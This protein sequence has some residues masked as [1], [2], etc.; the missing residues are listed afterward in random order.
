MS[1]PNQ[2]WSAL[3]LRVLNGN[4]P[5]VL[6]V[7]RA[8]LLLAFA[9]FAAL[10]VFR[11]PPA[12]AIEPNMGPEVC[13]WGDFARPEDTAWPITNVLGIPKAVIRAM[14]DPGQVPM[15]PWSL[16]GAT[17]TFDG[18]KIP[19]PMEIEFPAFYD[20]V[21]GKQRPMRRVHVEIW[22]EQA[23]AQA[24]MGAG[25]LDDEGKFTLEATDI[26][27]AVRPS[28]LAPWSLWFRY[29]VDNVS[30]GLVD[31]NGQQRVFETN[32]V[33]LPM[34]ATDYFEQDDPNVPPVPKPWSCI[35]SD[36]APNVTSLNL[37]ETQRREFEAYDAVL[38]AADYAHTLE[39][40][41]P[42][43]NVLVDP[44]PSSNLVPDPGL[45]YAPMT[46]EILV[47]ANR[48]ENWDAL[49]HEYGHHVVHSLWQTEIDD[50]PG[51]HA[52]SKHTAASGAGKDAGI[53][54]AF[55]EGWADFFA[56]W[57][58]RKTRE[59]QGAYGPF[60]FG[61]GG[62]FTNDNWMD[63]VV[64]YLKI[65]DVNPQ[66]PLPGLG[67]DNRA[68][69]LRVLWNLSTMQDGLSPEDL[70]AQ[71]AE[72]ST[73]TLSDWY[74]NHLYHD[75]FISDIEQKADCLLS[76][77]GV[78]PSLVEPLP[79]AYMGA[80]APHIYWSGGNNVQAGNG[81]PPPYPSDSF[82]V[83]VW[84]DDLSQPPIM[85]IDNISDDN[86]EFSSDQW[87]A[88]YEPRQGE[89]LHFTIRGTQTDSPVTGPYRS[90]S[91]PVVLL[92][93]FSH[94]FRYELR[95]PDFP[96]IDD[97]SRDYRA[98]R[99]A[100]TE[101]HLVLSGGDPQSPD[102][103]VVVGP[104]VLSAGG[105][106]SDAG[107]AK[108]DLDSVGIMDT[109]NHADARFYLKIRSWSPRV[110][111]FQTDGNGNAITTKG[112]SYWRNGVKRHYTTGQP[113][114]IDSFFNGA[115]NF[116]CGG[117]VEAWPDDGLSVNGLGGPYDSLTIY[118]G[119]CLACG[120]GG[121]APQTEPM[122]DGF[123]VFD[124][125]TS[126][127]DYI[128]GV[129]GADSYPP[130]KAHVR[131]D[132]A[133]YAVGADVIAIPQWHATNWDAVLHELGHAVARYEGFQSVGGDH[134]AWDNLALIYGKE[135]GTK[136]AFSEGW[137]SF[138]AVIAEEEGISAG[139][140]PKTEFGHLLSPRWGDSKIWLN[141]EK[142]GAGK[143]IGVDLMQSDPNQ[144]GLGKFVSLGEDNE[145]SI[146]RTLFETAS[147]L[148]GA[149]GYGMGPIW[150][151]LFGAFPSRWADFAN[152]LAPDVLLADGDPYEK[153]LVCTAA[154]HNVVPQVIEPVN[155]TGLRTPEGSGIQIVWT[156]GGGILDF[157]NDIF[158]ISF[159]R[160]SDH[161]LLQTIDY[162]E[163][164]PGGSGVVDLSQYD[165]NAAV[166]TNLVAQIPV[167]DAMRITVSGKNQ[168]APDWGYDIGCPSSLKRG[169]PVDVVVVVSSHP[170]DAGV[171]GG[172]DV[173][174]KVGAMVDGLVA[175]GKD[176]RVGL[177]GVW[178][179]HCED[180][181][182]G[183]SGLVL[184]RE[185]MLDAGGV[186]DGS[187]PAPDVGLET[188]HELGW[189]H[190]AELGGDVAS[191]KSWLST[192]MHG[193]A[194]NPLWQDPVARQCLPPWY[195][196]DF[197]DPTPG[198][199]KGDVWF[200]V[201]NGSLSQ[202]SGAV[203]GKWVGSVFDGAWHGI[204]DV[205]WRSEALKHL[206][207]IDGVEPYPSDPIPSR[208]LKDPQY[209]PVADC[210]WQ[211]G[212][213]M[214]T[215]PF[216]VSSKYDPVLHPD[217]DPG[218]VFKSGTTTVGAAD[219][220]TAAD[221]A[222]VEQANVVKGGDGASA[223]GGG[224]SAVGDPLA[225]GAVHVS[226]IWTGAVQPGGWEAPLG[227]FGQVS[228]S[229]GG[230]AFVARAG[231]PLGDELSLVGKRAGGFGAWIEAPY[232]R[233][234]TDPVYGRISSDA[235]LPCTLG[236]DASRSGGDLA[237][238]ALSY[239]WD[240]DG[241]GVFGDASGPVVYYQ[242]DEPFAGQVQVKVTDE[243]GHEATTGR[244]VQVRS[245]KPVA[246]IGGG[247]FH[248]AAGPATVLLDGSGSHDPDGPD[249][250]V[251]QW[252]WDFDGGS[253]DSF[254]ADV[255]GDAAAAAVVSHEFAAG[256]AGAATLRVTDNA[257]QTAE[258]S[259]VVCVGVAVCPDDPVV[260]YGHVDYPDRT[261]ERHPGR[262]VTVQVLNG[263]GGGPYVLAE[264]VT[265]DQG[266]YAVQ[267]PAWPGGRS[268]WVRA[269]AVSA[270]VG[271]VYGTG[272]QGE[273]GPVFEVLT[274]KVDG[275]DAGESHQVD[276]SVPEPGGAGGFRDFAAAGFETYDWVYH[277]YAYAVQTYAVT[278]PA[279]SVTLADPYVDVQLPQGNYFLG[280]LGGQWR[281]I[282]PVREAADYRYWPVLDDT[283]RLYG[284]HVGRHSGIVDAAADAIVVPGGPTFDNPLGILSGQCPQWG[285]AASFAAA[286]RDG[287]SAYF[288]LIV[289]EHDGV[290]DGPDDPANAASVQVKFFDRVDIDGPG[291]PTA[292]GEPA[293]Q[294]HGGPC[295]GYSAAAVAATLWD[296]HDGPGEYYFGGAPPG[297]FN[298]PGPL[299]PFY[300]A[301]DRDPVGP[302]A[303]G[304][305]WAAAVAAA[306]KTPQGVI[307][308]LETAP[309][310]DAVAVVA[311]HEKVV[312]EIT[313]VLEND[314]TTPE[315]QWY[316]SSPPQAQQAAAGNWILPTVRWLPNG[317]DSGVGL[318]NDA[319]VSVAAADGTVVWSTQVPG[320][321]EVQIPA[322]TWNSIAAAYGGQTLTVQVAARNAADQASLRARSPRRLLHVPATTGR[323][324][325]VAVVLD[326]SYPYGSAQGVDQFK[327]RLASALMRLRD[328]AAAAGTDLSISLVP[329]RGAV[330]DTSVVAFTPA[331]QL[332]IASAV[333]NVEFDAPAVDG[334]GNPRAAGETAAIGAAITLPGWRTDAAHQ[335]WVVADHRA[336]DSENQDV[337]Q[338][339]LAT[340]HKTTAAG[341]AD[342][343]GWTPP[344]IHFAG[345][346]G[347]SAA[348]TFYGQPGDQSAALSGRGNGDCSNAATTPAGY[349]PART[350]GT[351][352]V[353]TPSPFG[354]EV[355]LQPG[356]STGPD[357]AGEMSMEA[358][359]APTA[360]LTTNTPACTPNH[361]ITLDAS[362]STATT[363]QIVRY[364]WD[365]SGD[366]VYDATTT[367][368]TR[369]IT[370]LASGDYW[371]T[372]EV[373]NSIGQ[374]ARYRV[375]IHIANAPCPTA[376][377]TSPTT[378]Q[379][380]SKFSVD[381]SAST[382]PAGSIVKYQW[383]FEQPGTW[384]VT[385]P[386][387]G[388]PQSLTP[389][390][391]W[392]YPHTGTHTITLKV[393][394]NTGATSTT[395]KQ[396]TITKPDYLD[397]EIYKPGQPPVPPG[398]CP[399][400]LGALN[401]FTL[402]NGGD[403][404]WMWDT[405]PRPCATP[406]QDGN[407]NTS[408][409]LFAHHIT[410]TG[411]INLQPQ[412][413]MHN[414]NVIPT[415]NIAFDIHTN[416]LTN[417]T[418]GTIT[419][420]NLTNPNDKTTIPITTTPTTTTQPDGTTT[421][422]QTTT[423]KDPNNQTHPITWKHWNN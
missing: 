302:V 230:E 278:P 326:A 150:N 125:L 29:Y 388:F 262:H 258:A 376:T 120:I 39:P 363:G 102:S 88:V 354:A 73:Q 244:P 124:A 280:G 321:T 115:G 412:P 324:V 296:L 110:Q 221:D 403:T 179:A 367:T 334:A 283:L 139:L 78:A 346:P 273:L 193:D 338:L 229:T 7:A 142:A 35:W 225:G 341:D 223:V 377:F 339:Y 399:L 386:I 57:V 58:Q 319:V 417:T 414:N 197:Y 12:Q 114:D 396:I 103:D 31:L 188:G 240:L 272:L 314:A 33:F 413:G 294:T 43:V 61:P 332:N 299:T 281:M 211:I 422:Q 277:G 198:Q 285:G 194:G 349:L 360:R 323:K 131:A 291:T 66:A 183:D 133:Y 176:V 132:N 126:G 382:A 242:Y 216:A 100:E 82:T 411:T 384:D 123:E 370:Y 392:I 343:G 95:D 304:A 267:V 261:G 9:A 87:K 81:A 207:V 284:A 252:E 226:T 313:P 318:N 320:A 112:Q 93:R 387:P 322:V 395:T 307:A 253:G 357:C 5:P 6:T 400:A 330:L 290:G 163:M 127:R 190:V 71:I 59:D 423:Y 409:T 231:E 259:Q 344:T 168:H 122:R 104:P 260:V 1:A 335:I 17:W 379:A 98:I 77:Q 381:A 15:Y 305:V 247:P 203:D 250:Q 362:A 117:C 134:S 153:D 169:V 275:L 266:D 264:A 187:V 185:L 143:A 97:G 146:A 205:G 202:G 85:T 80:K 162:A 271:G 108:Y 148:P 265:D 105:S 130:L 189:K 232:F 107:E 157:R 352:C 200:S 48:A 8:L 50:L 138:F 215:W 405:P 317:A 128:A 220:V 256:F 158:T 94:F 287:W 34:P 298:V 276:V 331:P 147:H 236:F 40:T 83:E 155:G 397:L 26:E 192:V 295:A 46:Q 75:P 184:P 27:P 60:P 328:W 62:P 391:T 350:G 356:E 234:E 398:S 249:G 248:V 327:G 49:Q 11:A 182:G 79:N 365:Y 74:V 364:R 111:V 170:E 408:N 56:M 151:M 212:C 199:L 419:L 21:W 286:W 340:L 174:G 161:T 45:A 92:P 63:A 348:A 359:M 54:K 90:C 217:M 201:F 41:I 311:A 166:W 239:S 228:Q 14:S 195:W 336:P 52:F 407:I 383:S 347:C 219:V 246:V 263:H 406:I 210:P 243:A 402:W 404:P 86:Y 171:V 55:L 180:W 76:L 209:W 369:P 89:R 119:G 316:S 269:R 177:V 137:A 159:V 160:E 178:G 181:A 227:Q 389:I 149:K 44:D 196:D 268:V 410:G 3:S 300:S 342:L 101:L 129:K 351:V 4:R 401:N 416:L 36:G 10:V 306:A 113:I 325:D 68:S 109:G 289:Q 270:D 310:G 224:G 218:Q 274:D 257:G 206:V 415:H 238:G 24:K 235:T 164:D 355:M 145:V 37:T 315:Y 292:V 72:T 255:S 204:T 186:H 214:D 152:P 172:L 312:A 241:D 233:P 154:R 69:V 173:V 420:T 91:T 337:G 47:R 374:H 361:K 67:E 293:D 375:G 118:A 358:L 116:S 13:Q 99:G 141:L 51:D 208:W 303:D 237:V 140:M 42:K 165:V 32:H 64:E 254:A 175:D 121:G 18:T 279:V 19:T 251:V 297:P 288:S 191:F 372:V 394:D 222:G 245:A 378:A 418:T 16:T 53:R 38:T 20:D 385:R 373:T 309:A 144:L 308:Q 70:W 84:G 380:L 345:Q 390:A 2:L 28:L 368:P 333:G 353:G 23:G 301:A 156:R 329:F 213:F 30:V 421:T 167:G 25:V 371:P 96:V 135:N 136:L 282:V 366:G 65:D 393:T 106:G 22:M